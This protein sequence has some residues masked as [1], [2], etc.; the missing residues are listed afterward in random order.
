MTI[1]V[2]GAGA[3]GSLYAAKLA[4][5]HSVTV[6]ARGAH[7][8]AINRHGLRVT[9]LE[10]AT[11]RPAAV[12]SL[13]DLPE[14]RFF[15][16]TTKVNDNAAV[17][18]A[19]ANR[20]RGGAVVLCVQNGLGGEDI[21]KRAVRDR[22]SVLRAVTQFGAIFQAPG[23]I[24]YKVKGYTLIERGPGGDELAGLLTDSGLDGRVSDSIK[25]DIWRKL[26]F[27]C[28]INPITSITG[29]DVGSIADPRLDPLK[30][31]VIGE[32]IAVGQAE[33]V[34]FDLDFMSALRDIFGSSRNIASM[35]QDLMRSKATEI[36]F[37]NGAVVELGRRLGIA[38]PVNEA[39]VAIIKSMEK[40]TK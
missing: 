8:D 26:V 28:V 3:I 20:L 10:E 25:R 18:T 7:A 1:V 22:A 9:G 19:L 5:R 12:T 29:S 39:L 30:R 24:D 4:A 27:N 34:T 15:L 32:C 31:L 14:C 17:S 2:L 21:V 35:R 13:D 23:V 40:G 38:C 11:C 36:D 6:L 16:L 37:M 33:G